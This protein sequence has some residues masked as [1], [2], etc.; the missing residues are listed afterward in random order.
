MS[1]T[2]SVPSCSATATRNASW[3]FAGAPTVT[4][5]CGLAADGLPVGLQLIA[6]PGRDDLVLQ[7]AEWCEQQL[8]TLAAAVHRVPGN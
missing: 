2:R 4:L 7:T 1:A 6:A 3:S 8:Q 5:P